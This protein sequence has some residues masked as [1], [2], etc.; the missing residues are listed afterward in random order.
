[1]KN[2]PKQK[3]SLDISAIKTQAAKFFKAESKHAAFAGLMIVLLAYVYVVWNIGQLSVAE[4]TGEETGQ[5]AAQIP[6]IDKQAINQILKLEQ[7][8]PDIHSLF[9]SAR[10]NPFQE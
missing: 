5:A 2:E 8:S 1:M 6:K 4:P 10:N 3:K 9:D 7:N